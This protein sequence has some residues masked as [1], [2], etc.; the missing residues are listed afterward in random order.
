MCPG[1]N[2]VYVLLFGSKV[3]HQRKGE[4]GTYTLVELVHSLRMGTTNLA[5]MV[6]ALGFT[7]PAGV[8]V[9]A[10]TEKGI[11]KPASVKIHLLSVLMHLFPSERDE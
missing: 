2:K 9:R 5:V 8:S 1:R 6:P 4:Y 7:I 11:H 3:H 10:S